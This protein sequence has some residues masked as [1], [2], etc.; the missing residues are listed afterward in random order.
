[1]NSEGFQSLKIQREFA[2]Q[3]DYVVYEP[4]SPSVNQTATFADIAVEGAVQG[5]E[6]AEKALKLA[7]RRVNRVLE[8]Q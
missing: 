4:F 2:K 3:L 7:A 8:L 5:V 6:P 1:L